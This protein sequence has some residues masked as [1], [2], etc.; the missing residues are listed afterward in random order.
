MDWSQII[1]QTDVF[2][3]TLSQ[4]NLK[5]IFTNS[6]VRSETLR[7][8][9]L[10]I[11]ACKTEYTIDWG[12]LGF[13]AS[14]VRQLAV[15]AYSFRRRQAT[16]SWTGLEFLV[17]ARDAIIELWRTR[18]KG[19]LYVLYIRFIDRVYLCNEAQTTKSGPG[20]YSYDC[21]AN[22]IAASRILIL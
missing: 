10:Y 6:Q 12:A 21:T 2:Q 1:R 9:W 5:N 4:T 18:R 16:W 3:H 15:K 17:V 11:C 22:A 20:T 14:H 8:P 19:L 7:A 13:S